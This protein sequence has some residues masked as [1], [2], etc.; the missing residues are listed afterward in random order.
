M[1]VMKPGLLLKQYHPRSPDLYNHRMKGKSEA[2]VKGRAI[3][4][5]TFCRRLIHSGIGLGDHEGIAAIRYCFSR[6]DLFNGSDYPDRPMDPSGLGPR[7]TLAPPPQS[8]LLIL[9]AR[10]LCLSTD[11]PGADGSLGDEELVDALSEGE[12]LDKLSVEDLE[13]DPSDVELELVEATSAPN[14]GNDGAK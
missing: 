8:L 7:E 5:Y 11:L 12:L 1:A 3:D 6:A 13:D 10:P 9:Q 2:V 14:L 4:S